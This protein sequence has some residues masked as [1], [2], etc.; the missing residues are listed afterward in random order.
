MDFQWNVCCIIYNSVKDYRSLLVR[1]WH[2]LLSGLN[3]MKEL[4]LVNR[5][6][7]VASYP[8]RLVYLS[9][10]MI[11]VSRYF[12][13]ASLDLLSAGGKNNPKRLRTD[14]PTTSTV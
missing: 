12:S 9:S 3:S 5:I 1:F 2:I 4:D 7:T 6:K 8:K 10:V 13:P 11:E 14:A